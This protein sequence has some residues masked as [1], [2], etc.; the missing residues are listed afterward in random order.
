MTTTK[1]KIRETSFYDQYGINKVALLTA[2]QPLKVKRRLEDD[3][4][5]RPSKHELY[6]CSVIDP[7]HE[8]RNYG[9]YEGMRVIV[10]KQRLELNNEQ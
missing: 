1:A 7:S 3:Y 2:G 8:C 9:G 6:V 4:Y 10:M 5:H